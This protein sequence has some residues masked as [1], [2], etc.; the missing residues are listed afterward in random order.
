MFRRSDID[1]DYQEYLKEKEAASRDRD[2]YKETTT[3]SS[4]D[5]GLPHGRYSL[6]DESYPDRMVFKRG[7]EGLAAVIL[8]LIVFIVFGSFFIYLILQSGVK[9]LFILYIIIPFILFLGIASVASEFS[10]VKRLEIKDD[11]IILKSSTKDKVISFSDYV[12]MS[13]ERR[14]SKGSYSRTVYYILYN[15]E[16]KT[17]RIN[18]FRMNP[19]Q[20]S[21]LNYELSKAHKRYRS[22][23]VNN[24]FDG[25]IED[26]TINSSFTWPETFKARIGPNSILILPIIFVMMI[27]IPIFMSITFTRTTVR[28]ASGATVGVT[29]SPIF[30][31]FP[32][33][34]ATVMVLMAI[35]MF[36]VSPKS[37][38]AKVSQPTRITLTN[39][40]I[41]ID[42][43]FFRTG[44]IQVVYIS[45]VGLFDPR[46]ALNSSILEIRTATSLHKY[47]TYHG[48]H[49]QN[50]QL[51]V[52]LQLINP[53]WLYENFYNQVMLWGDKTGVPVY[54]YAI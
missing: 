39:D 14:Y 19:E 2:T 35:T 4:S 18:L 26:N 9:D 17:K 50:S 27:M 28:T 53:D 8:P 32:I 6:R 38:I 40:G 30:D 36:L 42:D 31:V 22:G 37:N 49:V 1:D 7:T 48:F 33:I 24:D 15:V 10:G 52:Q 21:E 41:T 47:A 45:P 25:R 13:M 16:S 20:A 51:P 43:K 23:E 3:S 34:I 54:E 5:K 11:C 29:E 46:N 12:D 44:D